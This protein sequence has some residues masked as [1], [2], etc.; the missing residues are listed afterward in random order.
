MILVKSGFNWRVAL[1]FNFLHS[2]T[3]MVGF[4]VGMA[5]STE[6]RIASDWILSITAGLFFY[7]S[8]TDLV[9]KGKYNY[10]HS[11]MVFKSL[12]DIFI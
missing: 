8:L 9:S 4:F 12:I 1:L 11:H 3:A 5:I 6:N 10:V 2:S 7:I